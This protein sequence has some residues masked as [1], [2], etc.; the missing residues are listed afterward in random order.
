MK[1]KT[2]I[3][4]V[5]I[6][7]ILTFFWIVLS[8]NY[9]FKVNDGL[10]TLSYAHT[11]DYVLS[12]DSGSLIAG[13]VLKGSFVAKK[14]YLGEVLLR[15]KTH[16]ITNKDCIK[17][18]YFKLKDIHSESWFQKNQ[19]SNCQFLDDSFFPFGFAP[20]PDSQNKTY[21]FEIEFSKEKFH[22]AI[23]LSN[24]PPAVIT[25]YQYPKNIIFSSVKSFSS[26]L[27]AKL[28]NSMITSTVI[29]VTILYL[30][31][32][33]L[34]I[35]WTTPTRKNLF[36]YS[37]AK[38]K[39]LSSHKSVTKSLTGQVASRLYI[40]IGVRKLIIIPVLAIFIETF[41][42]DIMVDYVY[43]TILLMILFVIFIYKLNHTF[44][45]SIALILLVI[46]VI[47]LSIKQLYAIK[48]AQ[49]TFFLL[50]LGSLQLLFSVFQKNHKGK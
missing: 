22:G 31:P 17:N 34:Y 47:V 13:Q 11:R 36:I 49:W 26:H 30:L 28:A 6:P 38:M 20:I 29:S 25:K 46:T 23:E 33:A 24:S 43:I 39:T 19:Y 5:I 32:L 14:N 18:I 10:T 8:F 4:F 41:L 44:S 7:S 16:T 1:F 42:L 50:T 2:I 27:K 40:F 45:F 15:L 37:I 21:Y 9:F 48:S 12:P 3:K 35:F